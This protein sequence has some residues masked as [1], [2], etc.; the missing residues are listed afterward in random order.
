MVKKRLRTVNIVIVLYL[1]SHLISISH[2]RLGGCS[3]F[4]SLIVIFHNRNSFPLLREDANV[5]SWGLTISSQSPLRCVGASVVLCTCARLANGIS[6][7]LASLLSSGI[8]PPPLQIQPQLSLIAPPHVVPH[9]TLVSCDIRS[10]G[11][12]PAFNV[13]LALEWL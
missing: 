12:A 5:S 8:A 9:Y 6:Y 3:V 4:S 2:S 7:H 11:V 13:R 1:A 10:E